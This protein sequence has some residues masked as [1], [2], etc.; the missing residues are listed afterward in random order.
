MR[1]WPTWLTGSTLGEVN[2]IRPVRSLAP[3]TLTAA[4]CPTEIDEKLLAGTSAASSSSPW[5]TI[6]N[7]GS[8][9]GDAIA[10]T[11]A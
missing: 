7:K 8:A 10:P 3:T 11:T 9:R 1:T 5:V 4:V 2:R 6:R